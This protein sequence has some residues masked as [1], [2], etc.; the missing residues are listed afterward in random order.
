MTLDGCAGD[1][2]RALWGLQTLA[3][4]E[5]GRGTLLKPEGSFD[6]AMS[7]G[8]EGSLVLMQRAHVQWTLET[9]NIPLDMQRRGVDDDHLPGYYYKE[10]S[11]AV[12]DFGRC[13]CRLHMHV[14]SPTLRSHGRRSGVRWRSTST[15]SSTCCTQMIAPST[16]TRAC[17]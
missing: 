15:T 10:D 17:R 1:H 5:F 3:I 6:R 12:S 9:N 4:N 14:R 8:I 2:C 13:S 7:L 16:P 11:L